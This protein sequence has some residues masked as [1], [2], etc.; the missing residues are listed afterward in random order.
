MISWI[1]A[2]HAQEILNA[3]TRLWAE[4]AC[5]LYGD[6]LIVITGADSIAAAY[7][8]G[9]RQAAHSVRCYV[10]H[11]VQVTDV[12]R[13][14]DGILRNATPDVG[15]VGL[16]GSRTPV[17]PWWEGDRCGA[18]T[19]ARMGPMDFRRGGPCA[20]LDGLLLATAQPVTWDET[21]PGWHGYDHDMCQQQIAVGRQNWCIHGPGLAIH[22]TA[23]PTDMRHLEGWRASVVRFCEKWG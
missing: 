19:D 20:Y 18:V 21:Y 8:E 15:M 14:R 10:H 11:D 16:I 3:N 12:G 23:G 13:L 17:M 7:N 22:N 6:E 1:V 5:G 9:T 4:M 2:S